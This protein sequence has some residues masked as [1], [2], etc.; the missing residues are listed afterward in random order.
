[1]STSD[2]H[3]RAL[4]AFGLPAGQTTVAPLG[5]G[6]INQTFL[7]TAPGGSK[8]VLQRINNAIF[9]DVDL[10]QAN[11]DAVTAHLRA[12]GE[13]TLEFARAVAD[14]KSYYR[15]PQDGSYWRLS[16][17][18]PGTVTLDALD[19][20]GARVTGR[21]FGRFEALLADIPAALGETIPRFHDMDLRLSQLRQACQDDPAGRLDGVREL[22]EEIESHAH[23]MCFAGRLHA[24]GLL[25]RRVCHC[26]TKLNNILFRADDRQ[27]LCVI[28]LDTVMPSFMFSDYGDF[29]R[30]AANTVAED[31]PDLEA[32]AFRTDIYEAF[33]QGYLQGATF[34]TDVERQWLPMGAALFPYMQAV[35]FLTDYINGDTYYRT[36]YP[37]H[38]L[39]R[40]RN[41]MALFR[42]L[43]RKLDL[44]VDARGAQA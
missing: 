26:D 2:V 11:I 42:D 6:L 14:G 23:A 13:P 37:D 28:D 34:L 32:V 30:T 7:A 39:V 3:A 22:V 17:Y 21:V 31:S 15:D 44:D 41:Q 43:C 18:V 36:A 38:N 9:R 33:T 35:R 40:T 20:D 4:E 5:D 24:R 1:M 19:A 27:P 29:L 10:L 8:W 12:K 25:P 16:R